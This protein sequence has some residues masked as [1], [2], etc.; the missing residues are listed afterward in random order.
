MASSSPRKYLRSVL[1]AGAGRQL[2]NFVTDPAGVQDALQ[3]AG[4]AKEEAVAAAAVEEQILEVAM[5]ATLPAE[6]TLSA[7]AP[8]SSPVSSPVS[9]QPPSS[10]A[11]VGSSAA[12]AEA[13]SGVNLLALKLE[14]IIKSY[15]QMYR[16]DE[17]PQDYT[18]NW[19]AVLG[20]GTYGKVY[21]GRKGPATGLHRD[22]CQG[23]FA[24]KML[25]DKEADVPKRVPCRCRLRG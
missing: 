21:V 13:R 18:V 7:E 1:E 8:V 24:I 4:T 14:A 10:G 17:L 23:G 16:Y 2:D 3:E 22:E 20:Q 6:A 19:K 9:R 11:T 5:E 15:G 25:R 12:T